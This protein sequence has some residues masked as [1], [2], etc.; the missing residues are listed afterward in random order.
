MTEFFTREEEIELGRQALAGDYEAREKLVLGNRRFVM[1]IA[2]R[3]EG[4]GVPL[5]DL[6]QEGMLFMIRSFDYYDPNRDTRFKTIAW[7]WIRRGILECLSKNGIVRPPSKGYGPDDP[8]QPGCVSLDAP[9]TDGTTTLSDNLEDESAPDPEVV[10]AQKEEK[11]RVHRLLRRLSPRKRHVMKMRFGIGIYKE[12]M[13]LG[14]IGAELGISAERARQIVAV[15]M[16]E[17]RVHLAKG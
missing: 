5:K 15:S 3:Y 17:M 4:L 9:T 11:A 16:D 1:S 14:E 12:P 7:W 13:S 8:R 10:A 6:V 2:R